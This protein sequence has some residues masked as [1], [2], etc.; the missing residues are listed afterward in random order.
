MSLPG[1]VRHLAEVEQYWF[2]M[3]MVRERPERHYR[4]SAVHAFLDA[5]GDDE[6][7]NDAWA[8]STGRGGWI[9]AGP[10]DV[11]G[12]AGERTTGIEPA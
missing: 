2:R 1:I 4:G 11:R 8:R 7:V 5:R 10:E 3:V 12:R 6:H 9:G